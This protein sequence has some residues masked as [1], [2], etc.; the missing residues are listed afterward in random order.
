[1]NR[2]TAHS[3]KTKFYYLQ[4]CMLLSVNFAR[5]NKQ[6]RQRLNMRGSAFSCPRHSYYCK[7]RRQTMQ[8]R[9]RKAVHCKELSACCFHCTILDNQCKYG[10]EIVGRF[11]REA[12]KYRYL[13]KLTTH[14]DRQQCKER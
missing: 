11:H 4:W 14:E 2:T 5:R 1:M 3:K 8:P 10:F 9:S 7:V 13:A 6:R 12:S